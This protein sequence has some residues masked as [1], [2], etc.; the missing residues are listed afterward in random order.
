M[1]PHLPGVDVT[2]LQALAALVSGALVAHVV[3]G[4]VSAIG[5]VVEAEGSYLTLDTAVYGQINVAAEQCC[6][7]RAVAGAEMARD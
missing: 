7:V 2:R 6:R 1:D 4:Q 3:A 5:V